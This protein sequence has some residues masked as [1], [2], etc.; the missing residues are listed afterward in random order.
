MWPHIRLLDIFFSPATILKWPVFDFYTI[1]QSFRPPNFK[2][3]LF[4]YSNFK[5]T[6][7]FPSRHPFLL[8][9]HTL[10][11]NLLA[12]W[13]AKNPTKLSMRKLW[14]LTFGF[15]AEV[16]ISDHVIYGYRPQWQIS[17][18]P[19]LGETDGKLQ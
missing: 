2:T 1:Y 14:Q 17:N 5:N 18:R 10:D 7:H 15:M 11:Q 19:F 4:Q 6:A 12:F 13:K 9:H 8:T 16:P 3:R